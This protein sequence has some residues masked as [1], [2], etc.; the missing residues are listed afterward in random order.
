MIFRAADILAD[1]K[2]TPL[3]QIDRFHSSP[4]GLK[5]PRHRRPYWCALEKKKTQI[6]LS[7]YTNMADM[8]SRD[9]KRSTVWVSKK[10]TPSEI[11]LR[12][13]SKCIVII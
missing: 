7:W 11:T 10:V 13:N 5:Q 6:L 12:G 1:N 9:Q 3:T 8:T 4:W 2:W